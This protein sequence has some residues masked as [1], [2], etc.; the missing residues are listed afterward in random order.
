MQHEFD[1]EKGD[2]FFIV[3]DKKRIAE[4]VYVMAGPKND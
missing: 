4:M 3:E 1:E 2:L